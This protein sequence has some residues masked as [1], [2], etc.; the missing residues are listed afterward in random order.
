[1]K[2][3]KI[4]TL[5]VVAVRFTKNPEELVKAVYAHYSRHTDTIYIHGDTLYMAQLWSEDLPHDWNDDEIVH[6]TIN[7]AK[8]N[9]KNY[10]ANNKNIRQVA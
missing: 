7:V 8:G 1:M 9:F 4:E 2:V 5:K 3:K 10:F 6:E